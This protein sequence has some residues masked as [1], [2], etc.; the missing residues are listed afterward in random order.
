MKEEMTKLYSKMTEIKKIVHG[1]KINAIKD[2]NRIKTSC[3]KD[4]GIPR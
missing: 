3:G 2:L 1:N 4:L